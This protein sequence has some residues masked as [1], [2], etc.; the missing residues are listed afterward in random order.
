VY[1][2]FVT[3]I[4]FSENLLQDQEDV[5][6]IL[7]DVNHALT[8]F[9]LKNCADREPIEPID[10]LKVQQLVEMGFGRD[11]VLQALRST[12]K[13]QLDA[14]DWLLA[15]G[16]SSN[17]MSRSDSNSDQESD[18]DRT[19]T[20]ATD[21]YPRV[22]I[23]V[24]C[25]REYQRATFQP[26]QRSLTK[27]QQMGVE[28]SRVRDALWIHNNNENAAC[29]WLLNERQL[30]DANLSVG[31]ARDSALY[32]SLLSDPIIALALTKPSI[33]LGFLHEIEE[34]I[35]ET[36]W[37]RDTQFTRIMDQIWQIFSSHAESNSA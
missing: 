34:P 3:L 22:P 17:A 8:Q 6:T 5:R 35:G 25:H 2:V 24:N 32:Q 27:M 7:K 29:E 12:K 36:R 26:N 4:D 19:S 37:A 31:I 9:S 14:M 13:N 23:I 33:L 11:K 1:Q 16:S 20:F 18:C 10:E 21:H 15:F 28:E 30:S